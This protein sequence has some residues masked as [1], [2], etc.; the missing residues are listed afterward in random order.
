VVI[1]GGNA[2]GTTGD[3]SYGGGVM[4]DGSNGAIASPRFAF[5]YFVDNRAPL[6]G[7]MGNHGTAGTTSPTLTACVFVNNSATNF[8][9]GFYT[10]ANK[11]G[12]ASPL[13]R[14]CVFYQNQAPSGPAMA[15]FASTDGQLRVRVVNAT[16]VNNVAVSSLTNLNLTPDVSRTEVVSSVLRGNTVQ[17]FSTGG[18]TPQNLSISYSATDVV[19]AGVGNTQANPQLVNAS[20]GDLRLSGSSPAID[21]GDPLATTGTVGTLDAGG[22][23]RVVNGRVDMGALEYAGPI[24]TDIYTVQAGNWNDGSTWN[25]GRVPVAG[26]RVRI[27]HVVQVGVGTFGVGQVVFEAG[28]QVRYAAGGGLRVE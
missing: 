23:A 14:S 27:R 28:G 25:I 17:V 11:G 18:D 15:S 20:V 7:G 13:L 19:W 10:D 5:C 4:N 21:L 3:N 8:G 24:T 1:R 9:G 26:E 6:G 22:T 2:N 16:L 12:V